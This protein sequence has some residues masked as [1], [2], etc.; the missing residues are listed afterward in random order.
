MGRR[1]KP[2]ITSADV[3]SQN[4]DTI[5]SSDIPFNSKWWWSGAIRNTLRPFPVELFVA[6]KTQ[7]WIITDR[8]SARKTPPITSSGQ[9]LFDS[10]ATA[11]SAAPIAR[12]P[13]SP[14][15]TRAGLR[16]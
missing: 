3:T 13:V 2:A 16:L 7:T 9:R 14:I 11:P 8:D 15:N 6:L 4:V 12:E 5:F 1:I 10:N